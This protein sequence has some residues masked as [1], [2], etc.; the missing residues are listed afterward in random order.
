MQQI[1]TFS[2]LER[3]LLNLVVPPKPEPEALIRIRV[4]EASLF[5]QDVARKSNIKSQVMIALDYLS[6]YGYTSVYQQKR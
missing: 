6:R 1:I 3:R 5:A 4:M 2:E